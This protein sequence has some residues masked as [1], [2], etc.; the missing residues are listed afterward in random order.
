[1][2]VFKEQGIIHSE[3]EVLHK[4]GNSL[5]IA[6]EGKIGYGVDHEFVQTHCI[7]QD[8]TNQKAAEAALIESE[9]KYRNI[10]EN[11][12]DV[13]W[14]TDL[15]LRTIYIS[16]SV[17]KLLGESPEEHMQ[18]RLEEKFPEQTIKYLGSVL[19][20]EL[21]KE[22]DVNIPK[23][24][25]RLIEV[26]HYRADG[27][28]IWIEMSIAITRDHQGNANGIIGV[29]RDI[30]Q[31][32]L[33]ELALK[34]SERSKSVLLTNL[35]GMAYRCNY[36][37]DWT[38]QFVSAGCVDLTGY[39]PESLINNRD[40]SFN[41]L[42]T[43]EYREPL[44]EEWERVLQKRQ[45]FQYEYEITTIQG[46]HKWVLELGEGVYG[47]NGSIEALEGIIIDISERRELENKLKYIGEHDALTGLYNIR[48]LEHILD[49]DR[50]A[51][52][53][54]NRAVLS[55]NFTE[56]NQV[57]IEFGF[58]YSQNLIR[59]IADE[60]KRFN[61]ESCQLFHTHENQFVFYIKSYR[62]QEELTAFCENV[63]NKLDA[64][65]AS[66]RIRGGI[67]VV[68]LNDENDHTVERTLRNLMLASEKA[69]SNLEKDF[70][71]YFYDA[72]LEAEAIR[73]QAIEHELSQIAADENSRRLFLQYQPI[74]DLKS[75]RICGFEALAR[76]TSNSY[77]QISPMEFIP[78]AEKTKLIIPLGYRI[79]RQ[80]LS[81][82]G[83]LKEKGF[84]AINVSI[85]ISIVQLLKKD[86]VNKLL[87]IMDDMNINPMDIGIEATES[88]FASNYQEISKI[89]G[90]LLALGIKIAIDD[91]GTGYSSLSRERDMNISHLKIDQSFIKRLSHQNDNEAI[92]GDIISMAHRMRHDVIAEGVEREIH[93]QYLR[94]HDCDKAQGYLISKPLDEQVALEF[95]E[96]D[97][98]TGLLLNDNRD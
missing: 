39:A 94:N 43:P 50:A 72:R 51:E 2:P 62:D 80:A 84:E 35:P 69:L 13:V 11:M 54:G 81:F 73:E 56:M 32:K 92:T 59:R 28:M 1:F 90:E 98:E 70:S 17:Q 86:F 76:L 74:L 61:S 71:Y 25:S 22:K 41:D 23:D 83:M 20:E 65:L 78:I 87:S 95:L 57:S 29:S 38:M 48:Y 55:I 91:F 24:R 6:F 66:E 58:I 46:E 63:A 5:F 21:E 45:R 96:S 12:S 97:R 79:I 68:V 16:P 47:E 19:L 36:D 31:R 40:L 26:E 10:A 52:T 89:L 34:E 60:L 33:A 27:T 82:S 4:N 88:I 37:R 8:I 93:L 49:L 7:L 42:I 75:N 64:L 18:R 67:G 14:Q 30:T 3:F 44:W 85:N 53:N 77:G 9:K 15:N